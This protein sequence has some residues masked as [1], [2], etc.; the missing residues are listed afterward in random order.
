MFV[1]KRLRQLLNMQPR[2]YRIQV[3]SSF[4]MADLIRHPRRPREGTV[5]IMQGY[6][7]RLSVALHCLVIQSV[8]RSP[9]GRGAC[10]AISE[11][12]MVSLL[13][14]ERW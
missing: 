9:E 12:G 13:I 2:R 3:C 14:V 6:V 4:V 5:V 8:E 10:V 1:P 11:H 7:N